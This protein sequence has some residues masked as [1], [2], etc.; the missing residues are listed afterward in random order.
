VDVRGRPATVWGEVVVHPIEPDTPA[1]WMTVVAI[2]CFVAL[3]INVGRDV[4][5]AA[6]RDVEVWLGFE[7]RG[8]LAML[9]AP[10]H[11]AI[12]GLGA[13]AF[14]TRRRWIFPWAA[15]Y[16]FY[17]AVSHLVWSEVSPNGRGWPIGLA[18]AV[19]ISL[20]GLLLLRAGAGLRAPSTR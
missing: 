6:A 2:I 16:L 11:W 18:Q 19:G 10:L 7:V 1:R 3:I 9:T 8:R 12:L 20:L 14:W 4:F 5:F 15:A 13:W 17:A